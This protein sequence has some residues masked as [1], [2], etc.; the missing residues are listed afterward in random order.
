MR[1]PPM[2]ASGNVFVRL[3]VAHEAALAA[4]P[5][6]RHLAAAM[7]SATDRVREAMAR[8]QAAREAAVAKL[9]QRDRADAELDQAVRR[10][11]I[12]ALAAAGRKRDATPYRELFPKGLTTVVAALLPDEVQM[13][14][15]LENRLREFP[16]L[17]GH[18]DPLK[19]ARERLEAAVREHL[20]AVREE[21]VAAAALQLAKADWLRQYR[22]SYG[23]LLAIFGDRRRA[24]AFFRTPYADS[25]PEDTE[26]EAEGGSGGGPTP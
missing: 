16:A 24:D 11:E 12:E 14:R 1:L 17:A 5:E 13:V 23:A 20:E 22:A 6:A 21:S 9:A 15:T 18:G 2:T 3:G 8:R 7:K 26:D 19:A 25:S 10:L 4:D